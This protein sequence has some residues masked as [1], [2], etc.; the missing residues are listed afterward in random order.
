MKYIP[1]EHEKYKTKK[2]NYNIKYHYYDVGFC[3]T[4]N[5]LCLYRIDAKRVNDD[6]VYCTKDC[7]LFAWKISPELREKMIKGSFGKKL[8]DEHKKKVGDSGR[9]KKRSKE[10]REKMRKG[11]LGDKNPC[12]GKSRPE[13]IRNK[14]SNSTKGSNAH[15]WKGGVSSAQTPLFET[16]GPQL[17][18][19]EEVRENEK[20]FLEVKCTYCGKWHQPKTNQVRHRIEFINGSKN[21]HGE[22]R[23]HGEARLYCSKECKLNCPI[24]RQKVYPKDFKE[25]T[26]R[27]VQPELRKM[28]F[29]LDNYECQ[30]CGSTKSLHCHH[31]EGI[32]INPIESADLDMCITLCKKC[33]KEVHKLPGCGYSDLRR[34]ECL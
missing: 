2:G 19:Y 23:S 25:A 9:G 31:Y 11:K 6:T 12:F 20:G 10:T 13:L 4:C 33:H 26:S 14:I 16:Y 27:E 22:D 29:E 17:E 5:D 30:K 8:S 3:D 1:E 34:R 18:K 32:W 24:Y 15:S 21:T 7:F 28:R